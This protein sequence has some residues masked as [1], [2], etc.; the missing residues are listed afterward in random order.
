MLIYLERSKQ[1][2]GIQKKKAFVILPLRLIDL[3][4]TAFPLVEIGLSRQYFNV[5][6]F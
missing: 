3:Q 1:K 6:N 2:K 4:E 5:N